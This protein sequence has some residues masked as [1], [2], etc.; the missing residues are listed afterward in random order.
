M[1]HM[2]VNPKH[3]GPLLTRGRRYFV[4]LWSAWNNSICAEV[5][6][7]NKINIC[8]STVFNA[9]IPNVTAP[10]GA[11]AIYMITF[12]HLYT[13]ITVDCRYDAA[14]YIEMVTSSIVNPNAIHWSN[15]NID[16]IW[17]RT[18][19]CLRWVTCKDVA[20][21]YRDL[22]VHESFEV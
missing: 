9:V 4:V 2:R 3:T 1:T 6:Q 18:T 14:N 21:L 16:Q 20:V 7:E 22:T 15:M 19:E 13:P 8:S 5:Y 11:W 12:A 17:T 10:N